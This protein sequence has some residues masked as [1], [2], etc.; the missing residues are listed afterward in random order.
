MGSRILPLSVAPSVALCSLT[1]ARKVT[2]SGERASALALDVTA[3]L[4]CRQRRV[5]YLCA[6]NRFDPYAVSRVAKASGVLAEE[7]LGRVLVVRA[8]TAYQY[9]ELVRRLDPDSAADLVVISGPCS[10]FF[11]EDVSLT[12]AARLFYRVLWRLVELARLGMTLLLAQHDRP[13]NPRRAYFLPDLCRASN[14]V[15]HLDGRSSFTLEHHGRATLP[16]L[17]AADQV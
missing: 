9:A 16:R 5:L 8:F 4:A 17:A 14:L 3:R 1:P 13:I 6:D 2:A 7:A 10:T 11:D 12:D 15:L